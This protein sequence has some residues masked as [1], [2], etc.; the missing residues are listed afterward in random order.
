MQN[1]SPR[2]GG[3]PAAAGGQA[4]PPLP[5]KSIAL[6]ATD[7]EGDADS[8]LELPQI[9]GLSP[10]YQRDEINVP[11]VLLPLLPRAGGDY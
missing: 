4:A 10:N 2:A 9:Q 11:G 6:A 8:Q 7:S 3:A 1:T 5:S